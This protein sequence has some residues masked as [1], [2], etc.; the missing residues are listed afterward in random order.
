MSYSLFITDIFIFFKPANFNF[1]HLIKVLYINGAGSCTLELCLSARRMRLRAM[2]VQAL[3]CA[4]Q[5]VYNL[6]VP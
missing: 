2:A 6:M 4:V 5:S 3:Q 1:L